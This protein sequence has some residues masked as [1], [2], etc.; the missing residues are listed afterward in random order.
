[1][2]EVHVAEEIPEEYH[3]AVLLQKGRGSER[4]DMNVKVTQC[5]LNLDACKIQLSVTKDVSK[6]SLEIH[7]GLI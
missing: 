7:I 1:M 4:Q 6:C 5:V 2:P 3:V